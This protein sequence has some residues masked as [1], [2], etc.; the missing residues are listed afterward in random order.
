MLL[1]GFAASAAEDLMAG[2]EAVVRSAPFRHMTVPGGHKMSV[3][4]SNCGLT[5]WVSDLRSYRYAAHD[6]ETGMLWPPMPQAFMELARDAAA[7][8]GYLDF[9]PDACLINCYAPGARMSLHQDRDER[10]F[11]APIVSV[12]LGAAATFLFG[13]LRRKDKPRRIK[14]E[15]GDVVVWGGPV[16]LAYHGIA[17]LRQDGRRYNLTFRKAL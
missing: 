10:D 16:R 13:G 6:P 2:V 7:H 15:H 4:M 9:M 12:S 3:A 14:L 5:G 17:P 8:A 11:T 1:R